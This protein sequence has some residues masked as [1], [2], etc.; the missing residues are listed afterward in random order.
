MTWKREPSLTREERN[1]LRIL[2]LGALVSTTI[3]SPRSVATYDTTSTFRP[4]PKENV[5]ESAAYENAVRDLG[6]CVRCGRVCR[7]QFCHRDEGKGAHLKTD[8]REGWAGCGPG[9][10]GHG[11]HH[12]VGTSGKLPK[13]ERRAEDLRCGALTRAALR[14]RGTW[15]KSVPEWEGDER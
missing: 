9:P 13:E 7:P 2:R 15:P 11:C 5:L 10:W 12:Y 8:V 1:E 14:Q 4:Q 3:A 6:Y